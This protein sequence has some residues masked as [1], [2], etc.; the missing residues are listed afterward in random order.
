MNGRLEESISVGAASSTPRAAMADG[1]HASHAA[2]FVACCSRRT[3]SLETKTD[4]AGIGRLLTDADWVQV[5]YIARAGRVAP[6]VYCH[7]AP[8]GLLSTAPASVAASLRDEY[9]RTLVQNRR[10]RTVLITLLDALGAEGIPILTL[11]GLALA[12]RYY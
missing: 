3:L 10:L 11:K 2:A 5:L 6:L 7:A 8:L 4:L 9:C 12:Y 1:K